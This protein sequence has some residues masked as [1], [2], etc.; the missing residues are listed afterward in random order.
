MSD[1]ESRYRKALRW[2]PRRW[3][4][5]NED[6]V[7]GTLLDVADEERRQ[8]PAKGELADLRTTALATRLGPFGRIS[9]A[10]RDRAAALT[11]GLGAAIG[12]AGL[13]ALLLDTQ[14]MPAAVRAQVNTFGPFA[15]T[16][17]ILY[18]LWVVAFVLALCGMRRLATVTLLATLPVSAAIYAIAPTLRMMWSPTLTTFAFLAILALV[19]LAGRPAQSLPGVRRTL[20]SAAAWGAAIA[21]TLWFQK[22]TEGGDAGRTDWFIGP[23]WQWLNFAIPFALIL[24]LVLRRVGQTSWSGALLIVLIPLIL[25]V[26]FG[27]STQ[28]LVQRGI[29]LEVILAVIAAAYFAPRLFRPPTRITKS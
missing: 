12:G 19:S 16:G 8:A 23:L 7:V 14:S 4:A 15:N 27:W 9:A 11:L 1:L 2:Y 20:I 10:V 21:G 24:A 25:F 13:I 18:G 22:A 3:R 17:A 29:W 28:D 5:A 26:V 6:A